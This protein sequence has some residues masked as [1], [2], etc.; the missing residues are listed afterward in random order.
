LTTLPGLILKAQSGFFTVRT[1]AGDYVCQLRGKLKKQRR[2]TD[3]AA[4]GDRVQISTQPDGT[5]MI[6]EIA[7]RRTVLARRAP[8]GYGR[9]G[10]RSAASEREQVLVANPDQAVFV[11]ACAEPAPHLRML[12]RL[13]VIA[14][15]AH[16]PVIICAN[17]TDLVTPEAARELFGLYPPLGYRVIYTSAVTGLGVPDLREALRGKLSVLIGPSGVGKS[18]LLNAVQP[19]L[20]LKARAVSQA[21]TKGRH[22]T[23]YPELLPLDGGGFVADTPGV[24]EISFWDIEPEELDGYFVEIRPYISQCEFNDCTHLHEPGCAVR[25]ALEAG[26]ISASRYESYRRLRAGEF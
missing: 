17:K 1:E 25:K 8:T 23:V 19:G 21:T 26:Q 5:G 10:V 16:L 24:R 12:D 2:A 14:E 13:I 3:L 4:I 9:G 18:T 20:G 11:F 7:P 22:T 6:E 15:A